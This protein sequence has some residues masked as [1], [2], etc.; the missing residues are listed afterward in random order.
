MTIVPPVIGI[1]T[2]EFESCPDACLG[3]LWSATPL[4]LFSHFPQTGHFSCMI[5]GSGSPC[6]LS[7]FADDLRQFEPVAIVRSVAGAQQGKGLP[8]S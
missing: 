5:S 4:S 8:I 6:H 7:G 3:L 2:S 1:V